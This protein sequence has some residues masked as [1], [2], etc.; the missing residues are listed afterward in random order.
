MHENTT[1]R[2]K[3]KVPPQTHREAG[4]RAAAP[5]NLVVRLAPDRNIDVESTSTI[6]RCNE[7]MID[8][9]SSRH[10]VKFDARF[11]IESTSINVLT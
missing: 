5:R 7:S 1:R 11:D 9:V 3:F 2:G 8:H 10:R 6:T 4:Q